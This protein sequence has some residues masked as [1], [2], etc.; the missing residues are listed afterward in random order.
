MT[1]PASL[2]DLRFTDNHDHPLRP[3]HRAGRYRGR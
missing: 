2:H 1:K 3:N